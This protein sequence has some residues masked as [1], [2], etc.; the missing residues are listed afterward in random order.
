MCEEGKMEKLFVSLICIFSV[1]IIYAKLPDAGLT[2]QELVKYW[3]YPV[4]TYNVQTKDGYILEMHRI[5][6]G[7]KKSAS[8]E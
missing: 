6:H 1:Q 2:T 5:P 8:P 7:K 4:E 3:G